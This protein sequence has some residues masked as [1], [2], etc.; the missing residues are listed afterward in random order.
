[1][2]KCLAGGVSAIV[3]RLIFYGRLGLGFFYNQTGTHQF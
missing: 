3:S 1:M 2:Q